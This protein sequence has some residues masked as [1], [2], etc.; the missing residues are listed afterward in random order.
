MAG[1]VLLGNVGTVTGGV[2][3]LDARPDGLL[4]GGTAADAGQ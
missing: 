1:C 3:A 4:D 2:E